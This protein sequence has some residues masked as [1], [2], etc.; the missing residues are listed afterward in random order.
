MPKIAVGG[1]QHET[2][3][4]V[5]ARTGYEDFEAADAWPGLTR[6]PAVFDALEGRNIGMAGL[7]AGALAEGWRVAPLAW[8]GGGAGGLVTAEAYRRISDLLLADLA[9]AMPVDGVLLDL[10]GAMV[11]EGAA[12]ADAAFLRRVRALVGDRVPVACSLDL[13]ANISA[14]MVALADVMTLYRSYPHLDMAATGRRAAALL[15]GVLATGERPAKAFRRIPFLIPTISGCTLKDPAQGVYGRVEAL[16]QRADIA[17]LGV[18]CGFSPS[19]TAHTGPSVLGYG[20]G[21]AEAAALIAADILGRETAF[22]ETPKTVDQAVA[23]AMATAMDT[24][25]DTP[26]GDAGP[27]LLAD[28][29]DNPGAGE[30]SDTAWLLEALI[31]RAAPSALLGLISDPAAV[32]AAHAAGVGATVDLTL[33]RGGAQR[34]GYRVEALSEGRFHAAG[35][36][37]GGVDVD[38]GPMALLS[39]GGVRVVISAQR[40]QAADPA[41][42]RHLGAEPRAAEILC[43]KSSVHFRADMGPL[44][45]EIIDVAAP[46]R[47]RDP[48]RLFPYRHLRQGVR[49]APG[50]AAFA[51]ASAP[52]G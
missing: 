5:S 33:G 14:E 30:P 17:E 23:A 41:M 3:T 21:A 19:D 43:L 1:F 24:A 20:P 22:A 49:M 37:F 12:D 7:L 34:R 8:C 4:F 32:A 44:A 27:V 10:H 29:D 42:F 36:Y 31:A 25:M 52:K 48:N 39:H 46:D 47:P 16:N 2:N 11:A 9:A 26:R 13:H 38:L 35:A 15:A 51:G 50:G 28:V 18:A 40:E 45:A 6:G